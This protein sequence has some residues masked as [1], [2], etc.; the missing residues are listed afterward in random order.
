MTQQPDDRQPEEPAGTGSSEP[1]LDEDAAWA[2]IVANYGERPN[3]F[4]EGP[5]RPDSPAAEPDEPEPPVVGPD[6]SVVEPVET[7]TPRRS[8]FDRSFLE[9][10]RLDAHELNTPAGWADEGHFVPPPPPPLP[11]VEP[12][13]RL[14]WAGLFGAPLLMLLGV[15]LGWSF[16][17]W[18]S[19]VVVG[20]FV[21]GFVYLVA[22]MSRR[23]HGDWPGGDGAVL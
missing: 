23:R 18:L 2:A 11:V 7:E 8:V 9:S 14:A 4:P 15:V 17:T 13:R 3:M 16:P 22:T 19:M 12:R 5:P 1:A 20:A 21:G 10:Q 6:G